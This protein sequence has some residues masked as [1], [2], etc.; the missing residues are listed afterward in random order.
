MSE[1]KQPR[2]VQGDPMFTMN[3]PFSHLKV[4]Q[5]ALHS[6]AAPRRVTD[7]VVLN[8]VNEQNR[9][10]DAFEKAEKEA[11]D[12]KAQ[13]AANQAADQAKAPRNRA[14]R[15]AAGRKR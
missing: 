3:I 10:L 14:T 1:I 2:Q 12:A 13:D 7:P 9:C 15:R 6:V 4:I 5:D 8:L 11:E